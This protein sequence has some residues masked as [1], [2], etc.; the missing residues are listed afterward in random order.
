ME[1]SRKVTITRAEELVVMFV[2]RVSWEGRVERSGENSLD[3]RPVI[4]SGGGQAVRRRAMR[5]RDT[6]LLL[7]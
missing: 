7:G 5:S 2:C 3:E 6:R 4:A 1:E